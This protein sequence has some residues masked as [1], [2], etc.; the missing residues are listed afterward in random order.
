MTLSLMIAFMGTALIVLVPLCLRVP[1]RRLPA[2]K[3]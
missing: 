3:D 1:A 2:T